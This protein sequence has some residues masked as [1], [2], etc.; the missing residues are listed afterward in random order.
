MKKLSGSKPMYQQMPHFLLY[1]FVVCCIDTM[2]YKRIY[3]CI[4]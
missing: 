1:E 4:Y 3:F 2:L